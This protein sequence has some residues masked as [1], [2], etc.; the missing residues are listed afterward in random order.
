MKKEHDHQNIVSVYA[1]TYHN[2]LLY[3]LNTLLFIFH[4]LTLFNKMK[5]SLILGICFSVLLIHKSQC[6]LSDRSQE[7]YNEE[8]TLRDLPDGKLQAHFEFTTK[9]KANTK[10]NAPCKALIE[11]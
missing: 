6:Q 11:R 1:V 3:Q 7:E 9:V 5:S 2:N 8:L 4:R 10:P